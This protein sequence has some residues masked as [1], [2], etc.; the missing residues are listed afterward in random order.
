[1]EGL[2]TRR[3]VAAQEAEK[4]KLGWLHL[5][6][7]FPRFDARVLYFENGGSTPTKTGSVLISS[8]GCLA[9]FSR[10]LWHR[11]SLLFAPS[12]APRVPAFRCVWPLGRLAAWPLGCIL[13]FCA[14]ILNKRTPNNKHVD[15][16]HFRRLGHELPM[17]WMVELSDG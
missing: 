10:R 17:R 2:A 1:M 6:V 7:T 14:W 4:A 3:I 12:V 15:K 9:R 5:S 11:V 8:C 13:P 16:S